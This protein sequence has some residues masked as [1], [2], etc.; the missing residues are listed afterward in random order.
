MCYSAA[1]TLNVSSFVVDDVIVQLSVF[2][3]QFMRLQHTTLSFF[4]SHILTKMDV[5]LRL[6][7]PKSF[8]SKMQ[9]HVKSVSSTPASV[10]TTFMKSLF[11]VQKCFISQSFS[12]YSR[13]IHKYIH[14]LKC[15]PSVVLI[16][17]AKMLWCN[18]W[19]IY[20]LWYYTK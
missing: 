2:F 15:L 12:L 6:I 16:N 3:K 7:S 8:P 18:I 20:R 10:L 9:T 17:N 13:K 4:I 11:G 1:A 14:T 5:F 19:L